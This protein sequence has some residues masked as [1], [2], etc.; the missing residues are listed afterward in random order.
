MSRF[1]FRT[2]WFIGL[3]ALAASVAGVGMVLNRSRAGDSSP[4]VSPTSPAV[5]CFGHAD[6]EHG[7]T[8]LYPVVPGR[9][10]Q[11]A[12]HETQSVQAGAVLLRLDDRL[13]KLRVKEAQADREAA[14]VQLTQSRKLPEQHHLK[15]T[16]QRAAIEAVRHR[17]A[18][19]RHVLARKRQLERLQQLNIKEADA[20]E[21]LVHE[22]EA[23][24]AAEVGK[25]RELELNDPSDSIRR[26]Q[27]DVTAKQARLEQAQRGAEE[28][29]LRA[30]SAGTVLRVLVGPGDVLGEQAKQPAILFCPEGQRLIRAEVEQEFAS[31]VA[32]G[33]PATVEDDATQGPRWR[34]KVLRVSDWYTHRRSIL[35]EPFQFNDVRTLECLVTLDPGQPPLKIGQRVRVTIEA[36]SGVRG[37]GFGQ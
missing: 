5:V 11:V 27:A 9:V 26:A 21:S 35:Q 2:T 28:C 34:G 30:P 37:S 25:L 13:A 31:R 1:S 14:Q 12:V 4:P 8:S 6:M 33:Q 7:V 16:E 23:A 17:L 15:L 36:G 29:I 20:A 19:A 32:A 3:A 18:G 24:E 22:L 10:T